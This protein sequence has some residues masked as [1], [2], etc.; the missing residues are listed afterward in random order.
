MF[1]PSAVAGRSKLPPPTKPS[2][3]PRSHCL[4]ARLASLLHFGFLF[5]Q[6]NTNACYSRKQSPAD[7]PLCSDPRVSLGSL[8]ASGGDSSLP[9][10][11]G[12]APAPPPPHQPC[13][14]PPRLCP[15]PC[16]GGNLTCFTWISSSSAAP[17]PQALPSP[18]SLGK[19]WLSHP[20]QVHGR[21]LNPQCLLQDLVPWEVS[22]SLPSSPL[23]HCLL[24]RL[25]TGSKLCGKIYF[26]IKSLQSFSPSSTSLHQLISE[27]GTPAHLP[28]QRASSLG[29]TFPPSLMGT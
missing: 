20:V 27:E 5:Q 11:Q 9:S 2:T 6:R 17:A 8:S 24:L 19:G 21:P 10:L 26:D 16:H 22:T 29:T 25:W 14:F 15:A 23:P 1:Q 3:T 7:P 12:A 4:R 28:P 13:P 18:S